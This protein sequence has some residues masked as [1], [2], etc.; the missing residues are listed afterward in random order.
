MTDDI[1]YRP[2][3]LRPADDAGDIVPVGTYMLEVVTSS[4]PSHSGGAVDGLIPSAAVVLLPAGSDAS[5]VPAGTP[6][7]AIILVKA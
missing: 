2:H 5:D 7:G 6:V 4:V 1:R 3:M